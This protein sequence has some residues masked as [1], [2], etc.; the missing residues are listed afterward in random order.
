[1][2]NG[3]IFQA[4]KQSKV[5]K[6]LNLQRMQHG[7]LFLVIQTLESHLVFGHH[8]LLR[9]QHGIFSGSELPWSQQVAAPI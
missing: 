3:I 8:S 5:Y 9:L 1:M 6:N 7:F 2:K 4:I